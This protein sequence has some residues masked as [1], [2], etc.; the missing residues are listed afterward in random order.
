MDETKKCEIRLNTKKK[1]GRKYYDLKPSS[2]YSNQTYGALNK[3]WLGFV[4]AK[5]HG[6]EWDN[7]EMYVRRVQKLELQLGREIT[8]FSNW[9]IE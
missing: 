6:G 7:L 3:S 8:D 4:I 9:G 5:E 2:Y 1:G